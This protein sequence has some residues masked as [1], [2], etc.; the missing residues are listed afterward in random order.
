MKAQ[1][2]TKVEL[3]SFFNFSA[4]Y[5]LVVNATPRRFTPGKET[6]GQSVWK[7]SSPPELITQIIQPLASRYTDLAILAHI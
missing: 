4:R 2:G 7:I 3:Y 6:Q 5:G 1:R